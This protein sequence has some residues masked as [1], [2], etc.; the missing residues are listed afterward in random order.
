[1]KVR[2][3]CRQCNNGWMSDL[4]A[5]AKQYVQPLLMGQTLTL[6]SLGQSLLALWGMKTAMVLEGIDPPVKRAYTD[7]DRARLRIDC[8]IPWRTSVWLATSVD[9]GLFHSS[10]TRLPSADAANA[11]PG[12]LTTMGFAH[13]VIQV[14]TIRVPEDVRP[15]TRITTNVRGG[16]WDDATILVWPSRSQQ[17]HWPP[18][19]GLNSLAGLDALAERFSTAALSADDVEVLEV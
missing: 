5:R 14:L 17:V 2:Y 15:A 3:V 19:V 6:D 8:K 16:P 10:K 7:Q 12:V 13:L 18:G 9:P 4:E 11:N 1:L